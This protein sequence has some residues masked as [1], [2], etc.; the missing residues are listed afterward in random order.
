MNR[1]KTLQPRFWTRW[2]AAGALDSTLT[3]P[4]I[5]QLIAEKVVAIGSDLYCKSR[6]AYKALMQRKRQEGYEIPDHAREKKYKSY[7]YVSLTD[8]AAQR[9]GKCRSCGQY[10]S[11]LGIRCHMHRCEKC[12][13]PTYVEFTDGGT[14]EFYWH[15]E[16]D[17][18]VMLMKIRGYDEERKLLLC[19]A[20]PMESRRWRAYTVEQAKA[21]IEKRVGRLVRTFDKGE[22]L[23][24]IPYDAGS[25]RLTPDSVINPAETRGH[26][27]NHSIVKLYQG[28]EYSEWDQ[29]P[30]SE[31]HSIYH[32]WMWGVRHK[33]SPTLHETI[34]HAAGMVS[35][36]DY[37]YQDGR[38]AFYDVHLERMRT[39]VQ[40]F[41]TLDLAAWDRM[42]AAVDK[43]PA[44]VMY[45]EY[46]T[47]RSVGWAKPDRSGPG[48]IRKI[49]AFCHQDAIAVNEPN[50]GNLLHGF[51][52]FAN[53]EPMTQGEVDAMSH[54]AQD[55]DVMDDFKSV[56]G[57]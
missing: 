30:V 57:R 45:N 19:Y 3:E 41:T 28:K 52:K 13:V 53:G 47:R 7:T 39:F 16:D 43:R 49:A 5:D 4:E 31:S 46:G 23:I 34:I 24:G 12:G 55:N 20:E 48:M 42:I 26:Q 9:R 36:C 21:E 8:D 11:T 35:R 54:A 1:S 22:A 32:A 15:D 2:A 25:H 29:L 27:H 33:P 40:H 51:S 50:I 14:I 17:S 38:D 37:Y 6:R 56:F 10:I 18:K 44:E